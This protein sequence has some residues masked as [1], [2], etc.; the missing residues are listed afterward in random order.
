MLNQDG[1]RLL[2]CKG[3]NFLSGAKWVLQ[4]RSMR[5]S[6]LAISQSRAW[7]VTRRSVAF[8]VTV[9]ASVGCSEIIPRIPLAS[10]KRHHHG[11][12]YRLRFPSALPIPGPSHDEMRYGI[13]DAYY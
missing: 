7:S 2:N 11:H 4:W 5:A 12:V 13:D 1:V 3:V 9:D 6:K 10:R 8:T